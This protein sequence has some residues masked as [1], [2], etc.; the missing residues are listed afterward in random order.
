MKKIRKNTQLSMINQK[1]AGRPAKNDIGIRHVQ[2]ERIQ[3]DT[4]LHLTIKVR[5]NKAD[6]KSKKIL[7][8]LHHAIIRARLK[9]IT[10]IHYTLEYDHVHLLVEAGNNR[11]LHLGMQAFGISFSKAI[12]KIKTA[13][14]AVYKHRYHFRRILSRPQLKNTIH[15]ILGNGIKHRRTKS[16][17]DPY[18]SM[19]FSRNLLSR[20][21][22]EIIKKSIFLKNLREELHK[23]LDYGKNYS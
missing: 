14:G 15:Y 19:V 5:K 23:V 17:I 13:K 1:G 3:K 8:A 2:R 16:F 18:N 4:S 20:K 10:I 12:N 7:K 6:I 22:R 21:W 9:G 11:V